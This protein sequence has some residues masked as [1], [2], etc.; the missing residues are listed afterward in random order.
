VSSYGR[1]APEYYDGTLHPTSR[2]FREGSVQLLGPLL[3]ALAD[4]R[5]LEVGSGQ[6]VLLEFRVHGPAVI[7]DLDDEMLSYSRQRSSDGPSFARAD[8]MRLPFRDSCFDVVVASLGDPYN[9]APFWSEASRVLAPGGMVLMTLPAF[10]WSR[11]FRTEGLTSEAEFISRDG[12]PVLVP[13]YIYSKVDQAH[14][15]RNA[16]LELSD[17]RSVGASDIPS[18]ALAPKLRGAGDETVTLLQVRKPSAAG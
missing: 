12:S 10:S 13:S 5:V 18:F 14:L 4:E 15:V 2:A 8:A 16:G 7:T 9:R 17:M 6:S 3:L 11:R 1:V